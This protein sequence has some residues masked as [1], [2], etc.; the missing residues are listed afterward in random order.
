[1]SREMYLT[2]DRDEALAKC[3]AQKVGV[4]TI[5]RLPQGGVRLVCMSGDGADLM[6]QKLKGKLIKGDVV[7]QRSR[8]RTPLW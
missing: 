2:I 3:E 1:M 6:R 4:S 5:E 7:R 8:P